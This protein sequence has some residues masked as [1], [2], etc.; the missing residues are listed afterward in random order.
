[1]GTN[2]YNVYEQDE[3][4]DSYRFFNGFDTETCDMAYGPELDASILFRPT[5][6]NN[7]AAEL[8]FRCF[9]NYKDQRESDKERKDFPI[10]QRA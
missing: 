9:E 6:Y 10:I 5:D 1:M 8:F 7:D 3:D 2:L 4:D